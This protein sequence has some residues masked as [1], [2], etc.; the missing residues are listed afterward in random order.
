VQIKQ[1]AI[2]LLLK[3]L[4]LGFEGF[5]VSFEIFALGFEVIKACFPILDFSLD[6]STFALALLALLSLRLDFFLLTF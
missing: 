1:L 2:V 6:V 4:Y 5:D 3:V